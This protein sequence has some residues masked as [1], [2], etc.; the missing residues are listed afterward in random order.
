MACR[1]CL[2]AFDEGFLDLFKVQKADSF[3][4]IRYASGESQICAV[5]A[6]AGDFYNSGVVVFVRAD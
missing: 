2:Q 5:Y 4:F 3:G 1:S 6:L